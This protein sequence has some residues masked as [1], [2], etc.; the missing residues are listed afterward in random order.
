METQLQA[1]VW[2]KLCAKGMVGPVRRGPDPA[3]S[4]AGPPW[5]HRCGPPVSLEGWS[6][7]AASQLG[8]M[9]AWVQLGS[10]QILHQ[11]QGR[12]VCIHVLHPL[13]G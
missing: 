9:R 6:M 5:F 8:C 1:V 7:G 4:S 10:I 12:G 11:Q 13:C 2:Q 3:Q